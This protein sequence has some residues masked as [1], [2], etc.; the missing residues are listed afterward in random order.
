MRRQADRSI[1]ISKRG[2]WTK[3]LLVSLMLFSLVP[4]S[5]KDRVPHL[6]NKGQQDFAQYQE[7]GQHKAFAIA[8]GG[9]WAWVQGASNATAA[10]QAAITQ[11]Q[12]YA[13]RKCIPYDV[14]GRIQ[15]DKRDWA[16]QWRPYTVQHELLDTPIGIKPGQRFPDLSFQDRQQQPHTVSALG[17]KVVLV[18]FWASWCPPCMQEFPLIKALHRSIAGRQDVALVMLQAREPM[19]DSLAWADKNGF[20]DLPLYD[21][22]ADDTRTHF[23]LADGSQLPDRYVAPLFPTTYILDR[24]G[25][26]LFH[27]RGPLPDWLEYLPLID[28]AAAHSGR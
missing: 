11:C 9:S 21:S 22:G 8:P 4:A 14:D 16:K 20:V 26:V 3:A 24:H 23:N 12:Q 19:T 6:N 25:V 17:G 13:K 27:H 2:R 1:Q 15:F 28:D 18:H 7:A 5:A 10:Q